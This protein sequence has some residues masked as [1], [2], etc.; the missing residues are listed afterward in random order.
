M[1]KEKHVFRVRFH[2]IIHEQNGFQIEGTLRK[3]C[4]REGKWVDRKLL[5][6]LR[7][8]YDNS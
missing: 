5:S 7:E 4:W 2:E 1:F 8:E 6:I 3:D